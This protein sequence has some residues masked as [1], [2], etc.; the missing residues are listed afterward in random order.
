MISL[1]D[2]DFIYID[3]LWYLYDMDT[4][5]IIGDY[6]YKLADLTTLH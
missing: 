3:N 6:G 5:L 2:Q 4:G 1:F